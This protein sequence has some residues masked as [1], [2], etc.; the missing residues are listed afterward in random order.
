MMYII[1]IMI[2]V[3]VNFTEREYSISEGAGSMRIGL[4]LNRRIDQIITV[5]FEIIGITAE[6]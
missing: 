3:S 2:V 4:Q 6:G 5:Q 1:C